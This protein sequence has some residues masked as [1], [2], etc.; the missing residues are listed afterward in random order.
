MTVASSLNSGSGG[1]G[2]QDIIEKISDQIVSM[3]DEILT[4]KADAM[5]YEIFQ[6][7]IEQHLK[8]IFES[9]P[10]HMEASRMFNREIFPIYKSTIEDFSNFN[11][12]IK[13]TDG[14]IDKAIEEYAKAIIENKDND[15]KKKDAKQKFISELKGI[16]NSDVGD[17]LS[18]KGGD[19][20]SFLADD[21]NKFKEIEGGKPRPP[22]LPKSA[23]TIADAIKAIVGKTKTEYDENHK[24][25]KKSEEDFSAFKE[26]R[27]TDMRI[28]G[29][30][31]CKGIDDLQKT[32]ESIKD[33]NNA[34]QLKQIN[35]LKDKLK[36][37]G[38]IANVLT[39]TVKNL[40]IAGGKKRSK[41][42]HK[43][44]SKKTHNKRNRKN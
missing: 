10:V 17:I 21:D 22:K 2:I 13:A 3:V 36:N 18:M 37:S 29:T 34:L 43:K 27:R 6:P 9:Y 20:S 32:E 41:K 5:M 33:V 42:T 44:R 4:E 31:G 8:T 25:I 1:I 12:I 26:Q 38:A 16:N 35:S 23:K 11:T 28:P 7:K 19:L 15:A 24:N 39:S 30:S 14:K 40:G